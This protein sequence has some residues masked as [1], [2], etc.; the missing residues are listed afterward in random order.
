MGIAEVQ[1]RHGAGVPGRIGRGNRVGHGDR[2]VR[3]AVDGRDGNA[4]G[5]TGGR[6]RETGRRRR[7]RLRDADRVSL[8]FSV[9]TELVF[10]AASVAV[11]VYVTLIAPRFG[12]PFTAATVA[13]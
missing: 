5:A 12:L 4:V 13:E 10:P 6:G 8:K 11:M 7:R 3:L 1:R 2:R 9:V